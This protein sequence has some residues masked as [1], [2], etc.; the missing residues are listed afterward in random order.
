MSCPD[1]DLP[2]TGEL[3]C[4]GVAVYGPSRCT[5][6]EAIHDL[7]QQQPKL[8]LQPAERT[9]MCADCA[10]RPDSPESNAQP[11]YQ[12]SGEGEPDLGLCRGFVCH[13]GMRRIVARRHPSGVEIPTKTDG[14][15]DPPI[16]DGVAFRAD[17]TPADVCAGWLAFRCKGVSA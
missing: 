16:V 5:C 6:W 12:H 2:D 11:N 7:E 13:Q 14:C 15:Y 8:E 9:T 1:L 17:G 4:Y 10:F 3:C